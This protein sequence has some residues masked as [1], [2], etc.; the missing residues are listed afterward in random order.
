EHYME[1]TF[2]PGGNLAMNRIREQVVA[3]LIEKTRID[4]II[5]LDEISHQHEAS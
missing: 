5:L 4:N 2:G 3:F 1:G